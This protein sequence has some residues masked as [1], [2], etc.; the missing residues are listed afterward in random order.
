MVAKHKFWRI[1]TR[2]HKWAGLVLGIQIVVWFASGFFMSFFNIDKVHG[3][4]MATKH[5]WT[6]NMEQTAPFSEVYNLYAENQ[7]ELYCHPM[8]R[9]ACLVRN[10]NGVHLRSAL[11]TPVWEFDNGVDKTYISGNPAKIWTGLSEGLITAAAGRYYLGDADINT[12]VLFDKAPKDF[13]KQSPIWQVTYDDNAATRL[14]ISPITGELVNVRTRLWRAFDFMW[15]LHIM[16]YKER[17]NINL[18][19]LKLLSFCALLFALSGVALVTHRMFL[20]P[21]RNK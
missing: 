2:I 12:V 8:Q 16:D 10:L 6:L 3:D 20:R 13:R 9:N 11:G 5:A 14:Y 1:L 7:R 17:D 15:M 19:W 21:K 4:H 18:W